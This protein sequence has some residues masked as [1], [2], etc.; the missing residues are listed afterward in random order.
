MAGVK[1]VVLEAFLS[2]EDAATA[3]E[4]ALIA[5]GLAVAVL[6]AVN[7]LAPSVTALVVNVG[8]VFLDRL[9]RFI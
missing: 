1:T 9:G 3:V 4:T 5:G 6:A 8:T 2:D 7:T